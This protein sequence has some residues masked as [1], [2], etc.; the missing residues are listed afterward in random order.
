VLRGSQRRQL[1][2]IRKADRHTCENVIRSNYK[3]I[4]R[5]LAYLT[6]NA[7]S[8]EDLTQETFT[9]LWTNIDNFDGRS[10]IKTWLHKIAYNKFID[11]TRKLKRHCEMMKNL[12]R[13]SQDMSG[14]TNQLWRLQNAEHTA[15]LYDGMLQL[16]LVEY[17][18]IVMHYVQGLSF[19]EMANVA[20][21]PVGTVKWQTHKALKR[22]KVIL[23]DRG[24][25]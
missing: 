20:D 13:Q 9:A 23:T 12:S 24:Q 6:G 21:K 18:S 19:R 22:L 4:Y 10:S 2:S 7:D 25:L 8:A 1:N 3:S 16:E 15:L 5:F 14:S 17:A 11:S